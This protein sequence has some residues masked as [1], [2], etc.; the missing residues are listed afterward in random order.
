MTPDWANLSRLS[1]N[2]PETEHF[3]APVNPSY[4]GLVP[5]ITGLYT[6]E[7]ACPRFRRIVLAL[8]SRHARDGWPLTFLAALACASPTAPQFQGCWLDLRVATTVTVSAHY[9]ACPAPSGALVYAADGYT[10]T[11][12]WD[13]PP[14]R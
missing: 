14:A 4:R 13:A 12:R 1:E 9:P 10:Y 6:H 2:V 7:S 11:V 5:E 8:Y 3:A